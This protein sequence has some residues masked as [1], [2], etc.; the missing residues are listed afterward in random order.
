[1]SMDN[2]INSSSSSSS[3]S[4]SHN[5]KYRGRILGPKLCTTCVC[6]RRGVVKQYS[7]SL[8]LPQFC[9]LLWCCL[10][11]I[12]KMKNKSS[13]S[14]SNSSINVDDD[15]DLGDNDDVALLLRHDKKSRT[16]ISAN[17]SSRSNS[18]DI[19]DDELNS[20]IINNNLKKKPSI[21]VISIA[22]HCPHC[23]LCVVDQDH[24]CIY[25]K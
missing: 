1:M 13:S 10:P 20:N 22:S 5:Y 17:S 7:T 6:N 16:G 23:D 3:D 8:V 18:K 4:V 12:K 25:L 15:N 9:G 24:H 11:T 14:S 19:D 21:E 2:N